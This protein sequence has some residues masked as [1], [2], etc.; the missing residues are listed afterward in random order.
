[1]R[2]KENLQKDQRQ[3]QVFISKLQSEKMEQQKELASLKRNVNKIM[4]SKQH[5]GLKSVEEN[6]TV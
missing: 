1:V 4:L 2:E 3:Q 5:V 6:T